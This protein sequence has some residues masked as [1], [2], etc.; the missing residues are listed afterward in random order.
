LVDVL[1]ILLDLLEPLSQCF[2]L[3]LPRHWALPSHLLT[4]HTREPSSLE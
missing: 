3:E 4:L 1:L 2:F